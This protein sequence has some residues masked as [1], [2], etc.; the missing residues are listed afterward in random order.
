V[1]EKGVICGEEAGAGILKNYCRIRWTRRQLQVTEEIAAE[2]NWTRRQVGCTHTYPSV[3]QA[4]YMKQMVEINTTE[5]YSVRR[6]QK[7]T[8]SGEEATVSMQGSTGGRM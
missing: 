2:T 1:R 5:V 6:E 7:S 4:A 3:H 8:L